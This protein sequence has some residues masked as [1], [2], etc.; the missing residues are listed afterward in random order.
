MEK[1]HRSGIKFDSPWS[2]TT[3]NWVEAARDT[4]SMNWERREACCPSNLDIILIL[5]FL[6]LFLQM[7]CRIIAVCKVSG[8][9]RDN[10]HH[11]K[12]VRTCQLAINVITYLSECSN[13]WKLFGTYHNVLHHQVELMTWVRAIENPGPSFANHCT[14]LLHI[15]CGIGDNDRD[16][17]RHKSY[18][19]LSN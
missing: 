7:V 4:A 3:L 13:F 10:G 17:L 19:D 16:P 11:L 8:D 18:N 14:T 15:A 9:G 5:F 2:Q 12:A 1:A 6:E